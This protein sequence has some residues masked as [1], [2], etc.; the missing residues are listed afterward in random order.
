MHATTAT[1]VHHGH[2]HLGDVELIA[3][4]L[5]QG[6]P[7]LMAAAAVLSRHGGLDGLSRAD[8]LDLI[9]PELGLAAATRLHA[10]LVLGRRVLQAS[11]PRIEPILT[12]EAAHARM[13]PSLTALGAEELHALYLDRRR[14]PLAHR[15]LT[16]GSAQFTIV[17]PRQIYRPAVQLGAAAVLLAHNHPSG[18]PEPSAQDHQVTR[19][20]AEAGRTLGI[21]LLDHLV[22]AG[23]TY[24]SLAARGTLPL[25]GDSAYAECAAGYTR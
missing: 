16:R 20:V 23:D 7:G 14:A 13:G 2:E 11:G 5:G 24:T 6:A 12:P 18:D 8:V 21:P 22:I 19:R 4:V 9:T 3:T 1:Y 25:P 10:A 17:D 15:R